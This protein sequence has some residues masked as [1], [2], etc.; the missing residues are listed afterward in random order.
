MQSASVIKIFI[1]GAVYERGVYAAECGK[2]LILMGE[3]YDGTERASD[4]DD[5]GQ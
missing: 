2:E 1:M 3:A 4:S 5:C